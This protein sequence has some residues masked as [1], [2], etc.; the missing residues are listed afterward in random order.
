MG[1]EIERKFL[2]RD[3]SIIEDYEGVYYHQGYLS[4]E[5]DRVV[6]VRIMGKKAVITLKGSTPGLA[7]LEY[8]YDIPMDDA[9]EVLEKLCLKPTIQKVRYKIPYEGFTWELDVFKGDNEG[10]IMAEIEL[11][12]E[13]QEFRV[14]SWVGEEVSGDPRYYNAYLVAHPYRSW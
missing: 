1:K 13:S 10:L 11:E 6:R 8:E 5:K 7:R 14:P 3:S 4:T 12:Y 2:V 9:G